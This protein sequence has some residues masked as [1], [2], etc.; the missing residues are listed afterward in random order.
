[1]PDAEN[2]DGVGIRTDEEEALVAYTQ[3]ELVSSPE[4]FHVTRARLRKT[5]ERGEDL[6]RYGL[7]QVA[8]VIFGRI[9]PDNLL[10]FGPLH[11]G[12]R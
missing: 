8:D 3:P 6:H 7:A 12:S 4:S 2:L 1:M 9:G 10:H 5:K 11:F